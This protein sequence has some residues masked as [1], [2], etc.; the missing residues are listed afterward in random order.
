MKNY[1]DFSD[2]PKDHPLYSEANKKRIG[3]FKGELNGQPRFEVVGQRSK[4]YSILSNT[5]EKQTA[6][7]IG[8]NVRQQQLK[9]KNYLNCLLSRKP[10][11]VSEIRIGSE[12]HRIFLMQQINRALSVYDDKRYLFEDGVTSFSY[13]HHKIV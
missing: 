4:M 13:G 8:R 5:V 2:Y 6:K 3:Y 12:K 7:G 1:F 10:S 11:T 9:H